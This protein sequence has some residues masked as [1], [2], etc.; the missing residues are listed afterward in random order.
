MAKLK[1]VDAVKGSPTGAPDT[2][3]GLL[4]DSFLVSKVGCIAMKV[5]KE[6]ETEPKK[7]RAT[8]KSAMQDIRNKYGKDDTSFMPGALLTKVNKLLVSM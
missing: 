3:A 5:Q 1:K 4:K 2:C 7:L 8:L 6:K